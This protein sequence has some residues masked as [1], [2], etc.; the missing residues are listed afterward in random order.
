MHQH[1]LDLYTRQE[2]ANQLIEDLESFTT[3][4][5]VGLDA[6]WG[7]G[8]TFFVN[9]FLKKVCQDK[10]IPMVVYDCFEHERESDPFVSLTKEILE[11][12]KDYQ[13]ETVAVSGTA[14]TSKLSDVSKKAT[15]LFVGLAKTAAVAGAKIFLKQGIE[16]IVGNFDSSPDSADTEQD[17]AKFIEEQL[18]PGHQIKAL[19][20]SFYE[21]ITALIKEISPQ[22]QYIIVVIDELDRCRPNHAIDVLESVRHLLNIPGIY[23]VFPYHKAQLKSSLSHIYGKGLDANLY[24]QKFMDLDISLPGGGITRQSEKMRWLFE[25]YL[26]KAKLTEPQKKSVVSMSQYYGPLS[27]IYQLS[28]RDIQRCVILHIAYERK[29]IELFHGLNIAILIILKVKFGD[30]IEEITKGMYPLHY[31]VLTKYRL[32]DILTMLENKYPSLKKSF[33]VDIGFLFLNE[34]N[35]REHISQQCDLGSNSYKVKS[36]KQ[37]LG[38]IFS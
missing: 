2:F 16:E 4:F 35:I 23:F 12:A 19:K 33:L 5:S 22:R 18:K 26:G 24:L 17:L 21:S 32:G 27:D 31:D 6:K 7:D 1:V 36:I 30:L 13:M 29:N 25:Q 15:S 14:I 34:P 28:P 9:N 3:P 20:E 10:D 11:L 37:V 38:A 8:K